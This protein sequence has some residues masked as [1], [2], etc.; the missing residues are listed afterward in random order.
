MRSA[1]SLRQ[2]ESR[3]AGAVPQTP[4]FNAWVPIPNGRR[5]ASCRPI[6]S[7]P[8]ERRSSCFPAELYPPPRSKVLYLFEGRCRGGNST[9]RRQTKHDSAGCSIGVALRQLEIPAVGANS[10][11]TL[12]AGLRPERTEPGRTM[13]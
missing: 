3:E 7:W 9:E 13:L 5:A 1:V 11:R 8:L 2:H 4:G 12:D 10:K 6:G